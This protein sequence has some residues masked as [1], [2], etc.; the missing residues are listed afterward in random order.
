MRPESTI[1]LVILNGREIRITTKASSSSRSSLFGT[2]FTLHILL[3]IRV[4]NSDVSTTDGAGFLEGVTVLVLLLLVVAL[5]EAREATLLLEVEGFLL[6]EG[7]VERLK[8]KVRVTVNEGL[9]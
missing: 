6:H 3:I 2:S 8:D 5:L 7:D 4:S 1:V 9:D